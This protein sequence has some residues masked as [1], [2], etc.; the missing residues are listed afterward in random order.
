MM[1][2]CVTDMSEGLF[3]EREKM[4]SHRFLSESKVNSWFC[5]WIGFRRFGNFQSNDMG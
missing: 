2:E 1:N 3:R 5:S 4:N